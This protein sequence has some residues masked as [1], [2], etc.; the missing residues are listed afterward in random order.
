M[1]KKEVK[2]VLLQPVS[3]HKSD[4]SSSQKIA[5]QEIV[6]WVYSRKNRHNMVY[7]LGGPAGTG[8]AQPDDTP[9]PTPNGWRR[10]G[11]LEVG[12]Y[13]FNRH[14]K[15]T[16]IIGV[17][18]QGVI[19]AYRITFNDGRS[20]FSSYDH[21]WTTVNLDGVN[22]ATTTLGDI[23]ERLKSGEAIYVP[24]HPGVEYSAQY[25]GVDPQEYGLY[26]RSSPDG[27]IDESFLYNSMWTR[28][29]V[30]YGLAMQNCRIN[31][32]SLLVIDVVNPDMVPDVLTLARSLGYQAFIAQE[33]TK[34]GESRVYVN[35]ARQPLKITSVEYVNEVP[36]RCIYVDDIDHLYLTE[37]YVVTH[38]T[39]LIRYLLSKLDLSQS[40]CYVVAYT[41]QAVNVLRQG[42]IYA[43]TIHS[44]FMTAVQR[45]LIV[46]GKV[47][48]RRGIPVTV[49]RFIPRKSIPS[50]VKLI[51]C[52]ESS[53][54]PEKL[55]E[56]MLRYNV[57][58]L[59][60]GDPFQ[61]PPVAGKQCFTMDRLDYVLTEIMR[62][63]ED[64]EIIDMATRFREG[65]RIPLKKYYKDVRFLIGKPS[66]EDT[67][68]R[69]FPFFRFSDIILTVTN[70]DRTAITD[71]YRKEILKTSNPFPIKGER[72][73][74]RR[75]EW[76]TV[77]ADFPLT[78]GTQGYAVNTV[79]KSMV[80][81]TNHFFLLNF[82]PIFLEDA[83]HD[84]L[85][86]DS[87]YI[88]KDFST[89]Q[90]NK[91]QVGFMKFEYA[92]AI[93]THLSQGSTYDSIL[94]M[95]RYM[96]YLNNDEYAARLR[97]TA[98]TRARDHVS[99]ILP[100]SRYGYGD[101]Y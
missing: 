98:V 80:N 14:G 58:I 1:K 81:Y 10:L 17:Y 74:C 27:R 73:I 49:T 24:T 33:K 65:Q 3:I 7:R 95:D 70:K 46:N 8:K 20:T 12:D 25:I 11:D 93:T 9:V 99:Y 62:Q 2:P 38:N 30:L 51:I 85:A 39:T 52:D 92:H 5:Y 19:P 34:T 6:D 32:S 13:V 43:K 64:S 90:E 4:L 72:L 50:S 67:F 75:N 21:L 35:T 15:P 22:W 26:V 83:Y 89:E 86:C 78:N 87:D 18:P 40:E 23:M 48:K 94:F 57:P 96:G 71:L 76:G 56:M 79:S 42:G 59:E 54:L 66:A 41:G 84:G 77:L 16:K 97:Y 63:N 29:N 53:F 91:Y 69:F 44:T 88:Q 28:M 101:Y 55:E 100:A 36:Q 82:R 60:I 68:H 45:P 31:T 61:L 47:V 37:G